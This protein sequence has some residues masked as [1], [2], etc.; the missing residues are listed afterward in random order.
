[1]SRVGRKPVLVPDTIKVTIE[2][3][4]I[5]V[6][7]PKGKL[8]TPVPKGV[9]VRMED[10]QLIV[11]APEAARGNRGFQGTMRAILSNMVTGVSKGYEGAVEI[12]GVGYKAE[13]RGGDTVRFLLGYTEPRDVKIDP[14][15]KV[16][17]D[18]AQTT[19]LVSGPDKQVVFQTL[20]L[21]RSLKQ[22]EPYKGKG[23][24]YRGEIIRRKAGKAGSK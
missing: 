13:M 17:V 18:K 11:E 10:K 2:S 15:L 19:V 20:A 23:L 16:V 21:M 12:S 5:S 8:F 4:Q 3:A 24:K 14:M 7:G 9:V 1:M 22:A 6:E